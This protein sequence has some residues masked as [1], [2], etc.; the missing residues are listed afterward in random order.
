[1]LK[2]I[3][4]DKKLKNLILNEREAAEGKI[5]LDSYPRQIHILLNSQCNLKCIMCGV[6]GGKYKLSDAKFKELMQLMPYLQLLILQG[7]EVFLD[8]RINTILKQAV[9]HK[10]KVDLFT[11]GLLI[12]R[13]T[14]EMIAEGNINLI[15][16][17]D[18]PFKEDY[19]AIRQGSDFEK[20]KENISFFNKVRKQKKSQ[21][22]TAVNMVVMKRNYKQIGEMIKFASRHKFDTLILSAVTGSLPDK[23][24]NFFDGFRDKKII[25]ELKEAMPLYEKQAAAAGIHL[26]NHMPLNA[27]KQTKPQSRNSFCKIPFLRISI[28]DRFYSP[29]CRCPDKQENKK[30]DSILEMWNGPAMINYR[31]KVL[32]VKKPKNFCS[33]CFQNQKHG[34]CR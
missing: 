19:Q 25:K 8:K 13:K 27:G 18:S 17:I 15:F 1:M 22:Q 9:K 10:V 31:K 7:G 5:I 16:S 2:K 33:A 21:V 24:E 11:N 6:R 29:D 34:V 14:A 28:D 30:Y 32:N 23:S 26:F 12:N 4:Q 3:M 20:L